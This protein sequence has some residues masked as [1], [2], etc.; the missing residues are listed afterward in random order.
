MIDKERKTV[1]LQEYDYSSNGAYFVTLCTQDKKRLFWKVGKKELNDQGCMALKWLL[2][3][4][5]KFVGI[6]LDCYVIMPNH[7]HCI[8]LFEDA[9]VDLQTVMDWYK[10]MTTN[11]YIRE[12]KAGRFLPFEKRVWQR[13]YYEHVIRNEQDLQ[14]TRRYILGNPLKQEK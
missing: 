4:P 5:R 9:A 1:R 13:S 12:V 10:T 8:F 11:A 7:L 14:E 3:I 6:S 2:E